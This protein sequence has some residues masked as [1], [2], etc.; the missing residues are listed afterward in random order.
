MPK[1]VGEAR[2]KALADLPGWSLAE[3][4]DAICRTF[5][6]DDFS[7]AFG[8]M[9]RVALAAEK[10]DHHPDWTNVYNRVDIELTSHDLGGISE[11]DVRLARSINS[12]VGEGAADETG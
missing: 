11:R 10:M 2:E 12:L 5:R 3:G 4:R 7:A 9:S 1:L 8:F 6:F